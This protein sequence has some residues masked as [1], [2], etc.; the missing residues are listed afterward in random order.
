MLYFNRFI[1]SRSFFKRQIA[2]LISRR[3]DEGKYRIDWKENAKSIY[4]LLYIHH[5]S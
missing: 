5:K 1:Y 2:I 4:R 3:K